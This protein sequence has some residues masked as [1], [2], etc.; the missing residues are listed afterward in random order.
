M[1]MSLNFQSTNFSEQI[2]CS[3]KDQ[4]LQTILALFMDVAC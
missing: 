4:A 1:A 3:W 2:D